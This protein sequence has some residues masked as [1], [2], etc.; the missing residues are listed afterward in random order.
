MKRILF[1]ASSITL[2]AAVAYADP[3]ADREAVMKSFGQSMGQLAPYAK[4]EKP[5]DAAEVQAALAT[6]NERAQKLDVAAL[7]PEGSM[8]N[9]EAS[10]KIWEDW[11]GFEAKANELKAASQAAVDA[12]PADLEAFRTAFGRVGASCGGC[13]EVF[14]VKKD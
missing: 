8:G 10:P 5:Y 11:A 4:G 3:A 13:H 9:T 14:R 12:A 7:F 6:L 2:V 1:A